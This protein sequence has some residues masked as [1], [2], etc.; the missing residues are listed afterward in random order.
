MP[1][2]HVVAFNGQHVSAVQ[3]DLLGWSVPAH[4]SSKGRVQRIGGDF[5][6]EIFS[7]LGNHLPGAHQLPQALPIQCNREAFAI[8][9]PSKCVQ[10]PRP[11]VTLRQMDSLNY[12]SECN[13]SRASKHR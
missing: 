4:D 10:C 2:R 5:E 8:H 12:E 1:L 3:I 6:G 13:Q 7:A 11:F 9:F